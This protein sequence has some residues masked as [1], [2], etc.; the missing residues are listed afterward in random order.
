MMKKTSWTAALL[1]LVFLFTLTASSCR[2]QDNPSG[3]DLT[4][5]SSAAES[6]SNS[7]KEESN[8]TT[9][10]SKVNSSKAPVSS[11]AGSNTKPTATKG[12]YQVSKQ[13]FTYMW[14][15]LGIRTSEKLCNIATGYYGM[16]YDAK[17]AK[18]KK[19]GAFSSANDRERTFTNQDN[20]LINT[21]PDIL[22]M[23]YSMTAGGN[24]YKINRV[25]SATDPSNPLRVIDSGTYVQHCDIWQ[26]QFGGNATPA[27]ASFSALSSYL[28]YSFHVDA[29]KTS[30]ET[31]LSVS[32]K[33]NPSFSQFKTY[34][35]KKA[36]SVTNASGA[37][38][39]FVSP[40]DCNDTF[41]FDAASKTLTVS[42][43]KALRKTKD[44]SRDVWDGLDFICAPTS[45]VSEK[46]VQQHL[47]LQQVEVSG[48]HLEPAMSAATVAYNPE[49]GVYD[50]SVPN[51]AGYADNR[52][53]NHDH[54]GKMR[55][56]VSNPTDSDLTVPL[57]FY[58]RES[59]GSSNANVTGVAPIIRDI[60]TQEPTGISVQISKNWHKMN[61]YVLY[62]GYWFNGYTY[63][64]VPAGKTVQYELVMAYA[65]WGNA[66]QANHAQL[67]LAGYTQ[68]DSN[69]LW[70]TSGLGCFI[71]EAFCYDVDVAQGRAMIDDMRILA[72]EANDGAGTGSKKF[73]FTNDVGGGNYFLWYDQQNQLQNLINMKV[74][75][76]NYAPN[77]TDV[78]FSGKTPGGEAEITVTT[79]L[80]RTT[81]I[82]RNY[83]TIKATF[84][85]D[86]SFTRLAFFTMGAD[87]YNDTIWSNV[88]YGNANGL[89][90]DIA[91]NTSERYAG[92]LKNEPKQVA[93]PGS[94]VWVSWYGAKRST[95]GHK[96]DTKG[97][98]GTRTMII[99]SYSAMIN[100]KAYTQP[101]VSFYHTDNNGQPSV[102]GEIT[103]PA[104]AGG[105]IKAGSTV[106]FTVE[107]LV[108]PQIKAEYYGPSAVLKSISDAAFDTWKIGHQY[109]SK[110]QISVS[111]SKGNLQNTFPIRVKAGA[112]SG[113]AAEFTVKGGMG[114]VPMT[115]TGL[116]NYKG[117]RLF[118]VE[119]GKETQINQSLPGQTND[120]WQTYYNPTEGKYEITFNVEHNGNT[121]Q[122]RL[123]KIS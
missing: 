119:N 86:L 5:S 107:C 100:G 28:T 52:E 96:F 94:S 56:I 40:K 70:Q 46:Q 20:S 68:R 18:I 121:A 33:F 77:L 36:C 123:K 25:T 53:E 49:T 22:D 95:A 102:L 61:E 13:D 82:N 87:N 115:I 97:S 58:Q 109:A 120:Y 51:T 73:D 81:D 9:E 108:F 15:P 43:T 104:E 26:M 2:N 91:L 79:N 4:E 32:I 67:S 8:V 90:K 30:G 41:G 31:K 103:P 10:S 113:V 38:Y 55:F 93:V 1:V 62:Q 65:K 92:Y 44:E 47:D 99:R 35:S 80:P 76:V 71:E 122:Y 75:Y 45:K 118:K 88:A 12:T 98:L 29:T 7:K 74:N 14:W 48:I 6:E 85:K 63:I 16:Q 72:V 21:L 23:Q 60:N 110:G 37:G 105:V 83:M 78:R 19:L 3:S 114:F 17:S 84:K 111:V 57:N 34:S 54:Y 69:L 89:V 112:Q 59:N 106:S 64:V 66:Y 24:T 27:R 42:V 101:S 116:N 39:I 50:I 117:Y 11:T